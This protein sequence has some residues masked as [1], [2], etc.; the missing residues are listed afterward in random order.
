MKPLQVLGKYELLQKIG[1][2]GMAEVYKARLTGIEG[3]EKVVVVKKILPGYARN[4][5]FIK[6]L[7][8]EAKLTSV[9][10][11]PNIVQIFELDHI[12]SQYYIAMELVDGKDLLK[13]LA[14]LAEGKAEA[15]QAM[16]CFFAAEVC[17]GLDYAHRAR[18]IYGKTLNIIHRDVSPSNIII[19]WGGSVKI[20][21]FGVAKART[22]D[23]KGSKHVLRGKLGYM[24]PEQVKGEEIDHRSDI[25]S[26]GIVLFESLTLKR[27]FLGRSDL[28]TLINIRDANIERKFEKYPF[29]D[30]GLR[31]VLRK[32]LAADREQRY[33]TAM[34][35]HE[36]LVEYLYEKKIRIN[37]TQVEDYLKE[38][39]GDEAETSALIREATG[40]QISSETTSDLGK[41]PLTSPGVPKSAVEEARRMDQMVGQGRAESPPEEEPQDQPPPIPDQALGVSADEPPKGQIGTAS[42]V[43]EHSPKIGEEPSPVPE[44]L[45]GH[46]FKLRNTSG[47]VFGP[48]DYSNLVNLLQTGAVSEEEFVSVDGG[49]WQ[50]VREITDVRKFSP[51]EALKS[52]GVTPIYSG[53]ISRTGL[54][55]IFYQV[56]SRGL[57]GKLRFIMSSA[58]KEFYFRKGKPRH[59]ASNLKQELLGSFLL[60]R[61]VVSEEQMD[62][63]L[64]RANEFGGR[65]GDALVS[66]GYVKPHELYWLLDQQFREKFLQIFSWSSGRYEFYEGVPCPIDMAPSDANVFRYV[67]EGIRKYSTANDLQMLFKQHAGSSVKEKRNDY[68]SIQSLPLNSKEQR[69]FSQVQR[70]GN[71]GKVLRDC[72]TDELK[73]SLYHTLLVL[74]QLELIEFVP[75]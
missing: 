37:N 8:D 74:Y 75:R 63:A 1:A 2:G 45:K 69:L 47:Y 50:R 53:T 61:Q 5:S 27:L 34:E 58:Q 14:R 7:V 22:Q 31:T 19:S 26:L 38:V 21:D 54:V 10:Q 6:M 64:S 29:I 35:F 32:A 65:L 59:I 72:N 9:L 20:M 3:F 43:E 49:D 41:R 28:E 24:S 15:N 18:D 11:H 46:E 55:R 67:L 40:E 48:V 33:A 73:A 70:A 39:F 60:H 68:I 25:F 52:K 36:D 44:S 62:D 4:V 12:D 23:T 57:S 30:E 13:I 71:F 17:K 42:F 51:N 66:M 16:S 56:S